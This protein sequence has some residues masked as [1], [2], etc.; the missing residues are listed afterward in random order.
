MKIRPMEV[1]LFHADGQTGRQT[2]RSYYSLFAVL[3]TRLQT[4]A[5]I[6][7]IPLQK[8]ILY[9]HI[10]NWNSFLATQYSDGN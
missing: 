6:M 7:K 3:P 10:S 1:E 2:W 9:K 8:D 4:V 5:G